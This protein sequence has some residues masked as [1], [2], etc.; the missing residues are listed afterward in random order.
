MKNNYLKFKVN[1]LLAKILEPSETNSVEY[2]II[3]I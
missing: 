2:T 3:K 1:Y